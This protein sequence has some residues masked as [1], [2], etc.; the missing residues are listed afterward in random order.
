MIE[1]INSNYR[2]I[3]INIE[4]IIAIKRKKVFLAKNG[5]LGR[6]LKIRVDDVSIQSFL[7][8]HVKFHFSNFPIFAIPPFFWDTLYMLYIQFK[9]AN[10]I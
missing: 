8:L 6:I 9:T 4:W 2:E 5:F 1:V 3:P 10:I 7:I